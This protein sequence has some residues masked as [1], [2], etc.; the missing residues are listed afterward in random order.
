MAIKELWVESYRPKTIDDYVWIDESQKRMVETWVKE[1]YLPMLILSGGAGT[2]KTTLAKVLIN[3]LGVEPADTLIINASRENGVD[4]LRQK[5][6]NFA[7]T[8]PFGEFKVILLDEADGTS[9]Q[10][11][12]A[13]RGAME[14]YSHV[15]R[16]ILTANYPQK[17]IPAIHSRCQSFHFKSLDET[18]FMLRVA[19]ILVA[20]NIEFDIDTLSA[21]TKAHYPDL[22]KT[23]NQVQQYSSSGKLVMPSSE[24]NNNEKDYRL[25]MISLFRQGQLRNARNLICSQISLDEYEEMYKFLYRNLDFFGTNDDQKDEAIMVIRQGLVNHGL[26]A[27]PELNLSATMVELERITKQ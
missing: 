22:R 8:M 14:Q 18:E 7:Q 24:D 2:G 26:C 3:E 15:L 1:K 13:L 19:K 27:D 17:I 11:Q 12:Q 16:F 5:V 9:P 6:S 10:F 4:I 25:E 23:I 20:E 21:F